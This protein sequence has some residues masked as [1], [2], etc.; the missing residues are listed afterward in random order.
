MA[1]NFNTDIVSDLHWDTSLT[2]SRNVN[3][4]KKFVRNYRNPFT[5]EY[6]DM[7]EVERGGNLLKEGGSI[8]DITTKGGIKT[9]CE[10]RTYPK[11]FRRL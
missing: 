8:A 3:E 10:W 11:P 1:L 7:T 9:Q 2:Y 6:F 4:I 5:G